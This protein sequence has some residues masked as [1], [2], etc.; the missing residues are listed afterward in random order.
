MWRT[1][2]I[3]LQHFFIA[4]LRA[5]YFGVFLLSVFLLTEI[6]TV[7]LISRYDFIF[8]AAVGFQICA[9]VFRFENRREFFVIILFHILATGMELFKTHPAIG[10]WIYPGVGS[11][12]FVLG[13][14]PLFSGF[15]YSSIGSYISR[16]FVFLK[17]EYEH[18]PA[19]YHTWI[20]AT[21][22]YL[23]FFTHHFFYDIRYLLFIYIFIIFFKTKVHFEVY[24][25][26]R[27]M[28][29][30]LTVFLTA[31]F[32]WIAENIG[33]LTHIWLYP[34]QLEYWH[35]VSLHKIGSWFLLLILSF[36]LVSIIYR[37]KLRCSP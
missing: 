21:L 16:A 9:L 34:N 1:Y 31:L 8:L 26:K 29:F 18:F 3:E 17:L 37:D 15:L 33:T 20:L 14:V 7:P 24:R 4:N 30:L 32:V 11:A 28:P 22:I 10:S 19:Y 36:A 25:K 13:S 2:F 35:L 6:I 23:N 27:T 12:I 5:S